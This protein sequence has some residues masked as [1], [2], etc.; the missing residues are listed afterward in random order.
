MKKWGRIK[1][2]L[3][4]YYNWCARRE[5]CVKLHQNMD[6][7]NGQYELGWP[8]QDQ[9]EVRWYQART[10]YKLCCFFL[11]PRWPPSVKRIQGKG[12]WPVGCMSLYN[13]CVGCHVWCLR[14]DTVVVAISCIGSPRHNETLYTRIF[15]NSTYGWNAK[16]LVKPK[17]SVLHSNT[18]TRVLYCCI[19][20][21][22]DR[23]G[24]VGPT[25]QCI[26][27]GPKFLCRTKRTPKS[28]PY[29]TSTFFWCACLWWGSLRSDWH[30][31]ERRC[32][33]TH[34]LFSFSKQKTWMSQFNRHNHSLIN[35]TNK[36][37]N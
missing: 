6:R 21:D 15:E 16:T 9:T 1:K 34:N 18:C 12:A 37:S 25:M 8:S 7:S 35:T 14:Y 36:R 29:R 2:N 33:R 11:L 32:H 24:T 17:H 26:G 3:I 28:H 13:D 10:Y 31:H 27:L 22:S 4:A 19:G 20:P 30:R 23:R 5:L